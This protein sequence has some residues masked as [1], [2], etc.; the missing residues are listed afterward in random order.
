MKAQWTI[1]EN[2]S[3]PLTPEEAERAD[4]IFIS[5]LQSVAALI[6]YAVA[7]G[8]QREAAGL[9][10]FRERQK[11]REIDTQALNLMAIL[12]EMLNAAETEIIDGGEQ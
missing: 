9:L 2:L 1:D 4:D 10:T 8:R 6:R 11:L 12:T 3:E 7:V 5:E